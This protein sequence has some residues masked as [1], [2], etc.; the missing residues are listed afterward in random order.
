MVWAWA[1][2]RDEVGG[3]YSQS[4][5]DCIYTGSLRSCPKEAHATSLGQVSSRLNILVTCHTAKQGIP[6]LCLSSIFHSSPVNSSP[7]AHEK[8]LL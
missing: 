4:K 3:K 6:G 5:I 7:V 1:I 2:G 8:E